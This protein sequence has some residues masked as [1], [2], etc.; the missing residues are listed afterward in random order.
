MAILVYRVRNDYFEF[1]YPRELL[2][3]Y[4]NSKYH[5]VHTFISKLNQT[6]RSEWVT[7]LSVQRAQDFDTSLLPEEIK[8]NPAMRENSFRM[9]G[10]KE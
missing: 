10:E 6:R 1:P 3:V 4:D 2:A 9:P 5:K 8:I 7:I